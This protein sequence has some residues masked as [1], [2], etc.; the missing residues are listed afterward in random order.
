MSVCN[1]N[2]LTTDIT[3]PLVIHMTFCMILWKKLFYNINSIGLDYI[4]VIYFAFCLDVAQVLYFDLRP[5][6]LAIPRWC[7]GRK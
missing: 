3:I 6:Q 4:L 7:A 1:Q 2:Q 5:G